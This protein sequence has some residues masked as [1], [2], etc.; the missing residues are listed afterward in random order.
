MRLLQRSFCLKIEIKCGTMVL[1]LYGGNFMYIDKLEY[2]SDVINKEIA[3]GQISGASTAVLKD[4]EIVFRKE[5]GYA[6]IE[7]GKKMKDNTIFRLFSL[8]KPITAVAAMILFE[9][10]LIDLESPVKNYINGYENMSVI[11]DGKY[12]PANS[13]ITIHHLLNMTAG[14][15]YGGDWCESGAEMQKLFDELK[16]RMANGEEFT[17]MQ[18]AELLAEKPLMFHPGES[19]TYGT[20]SDVMGAVIEKVSG[21][22]F[23][24]FLKKEIFEPLQMIDTGF[25]IPEDKYDRL[26]QIYYYDEKEKKPV[27]F[28]DFHLLLTDYKKPPAFESGGAGLVSTLDDYIK[29]TSMLLNKGEYNGKRILGRKTAQYMTTN[30][31]TK[32]QMYALYY[33]ATK[34]YGYGNYLRILTDKAAA[35][36]NAS[37]GEYGW[38]GWTGDYITISPEDNMIFLYFIQRCGAG[39]NET[40]RKLRQIVYGA[41][42]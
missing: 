14:M 31:M 11:K 5:Y 3:D 9:R 21:M 33:G 15:V 34:G 4:G 19:W 7:K 28:D 40:T 39:C 29:F 38:D 26:A 20:C 2:M 32:N 41:L 17:T 23:S 30:Q 8:T 18:I 16:I 6:D 35:A 22:K 12:I 27:V 1:N 24:E 10:G 42:E 37:L 13:D 25:Y 36:T